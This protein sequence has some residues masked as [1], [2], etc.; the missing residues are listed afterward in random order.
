MRL[1]PITPK[2]VLVFSKL[3]RLEGESRRMNL[4]LNSDRLD[5][6][7]ARRGFNVAALRASH[8]AHMSA[9]NEVIEGLLKTGASTRMVQARTQATPPMPPQP[10]PQS[11]GHSHHHS[12]HHHHSHTP[13][14]T[15]VIPEDMVISVGGD[16]T[17]L[18]CVRQNISK[19]TPFLGVNSDPERSTG[20]LCTFAVSRHRRFEDALERLRHGRYAVLTRQR[21]GV[22]ISSSHGVFQAPFTA[23]NEVFFGEKEPTVPTKH[24]TTVYGVRS[25]P[26]WCLNPAEEDPLASE[27]LGAAV[28][29]ASTPRD[30]EPYFGFGAGDAGGETG[31]AGAGQRR[32]LVRSPSLGPPLLPRSVTQR[33]CGVLV[34]SGSG[35][36][37]WMRSAT[38]VHAFD[39]QRVVNAACGPS[40]VL[41]TSASAVRRTAARVNEACVF[42]PESRYVGY[43]VREPLMAYTGDAREFDEP[44]H[45]LAHKV[46]LRNL[47]YDVCVSIDGL[48][49][50][51]VEYG[52]VVE[53]AV[54]PLRSLMCVVPNVA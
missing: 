16:G 22:T 35:S 48:H 30:T 47:G 45:G 18:E 12:H 28:A 49:K 26:A 20:K 5:A 41:R 8:D 3:T 36:T 42:H 14:S 9:L 43:A 50:I 37:A 17:A 34:C 19:E 40:D 38:A 6:E 4:D 1:P 32:T 24:E 25:P 10:P 44:K 23:L 39:V 7:L 46:V 13:K 31:N 33:S 2:R 21:V 29:A 15:P 11:H 54:D 52:A 27:D 51:D 53:C